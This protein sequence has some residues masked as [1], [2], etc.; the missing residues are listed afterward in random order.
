MNT[1]LSPIRIKYT[2]STPGADANTY[3][4]FSTVAAGFTPDAVQY[5]GIHVYHYAI[6]HDQP[7]TLNL[8]WSEDGGTTWSLKTTTGSMPAGVNEDY[9]PVEGYRDFK[10]EWVNGGTAQGTWIVNQSMSPQA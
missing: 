3:V 9:L 6:D 4:L 8:Y 1:L 2:G 7:G 5:G 10:V